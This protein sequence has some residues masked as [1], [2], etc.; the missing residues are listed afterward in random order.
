MK[1]IKNKYDN[2]RRK[3]ETDNNS[4]LS[5]D[6]YKICNYSSEISVHLLRKLY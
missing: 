5:K 3:E 4:V 6:Y 2:K 1:E